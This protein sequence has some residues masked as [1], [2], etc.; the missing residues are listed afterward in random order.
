MRDCPLFRRDQTLLNIHLCTAFADSWVNE[1]PKYAGH[2][3]TKDHPEQLIWSHRR[4]GDYRYLW[5]VPYAWR[6]A[7]YAWP[8]TLW[9]RA[10]WRFR[11][12]AW[13]FRPQTYVDKL[14]RLAGRTT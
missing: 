7:A 13:L 5:R 12:S 4:R 9:F 2:M 11:Q 10:R 14:R 3:S 1:L 6:A 8:F